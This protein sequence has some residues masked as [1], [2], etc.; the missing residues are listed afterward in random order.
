MSKCT[1]TCQ[2]PPINSPQC[3]CS[4][5]HITFG[6]VTAFDLHRFEGGCRDISKFGFEEMNGVW[7]QPM[8]NEK[9]KA[10]RARV[11]KK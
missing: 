8:D 1:D 2:K 9:V 10:F 3:H 4:V 5:C 11:G 6:G 7:R